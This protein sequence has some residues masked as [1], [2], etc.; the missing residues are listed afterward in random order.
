MPLEVGEWATAEGVSLLMEAT[1][2]TEGAACLLTEVTDTAE[3]GDSLFSGE[4]LVTGNI[5][6]VARE[7]LTG[8]AELLG[9]MTTAP[10][11]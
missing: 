7:E 1:E 3:E 2:T 10:F 8:E 11:V 4:L 9:M 6:R 5:E